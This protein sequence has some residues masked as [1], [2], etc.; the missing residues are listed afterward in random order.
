MQM[1]RCID[2]GTVHWASIS[3]RGLSAE[4]TCSVC[5]GGL[6]DERRRPGRGQSYGGRERRDLPISV[7]RAA[8]DSQRPTTSA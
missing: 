1:L 2:C 5:G 7:R 8:G 6:T 3:G 4:R